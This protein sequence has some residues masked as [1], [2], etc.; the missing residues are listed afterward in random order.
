MARRRKKQ[1]LDDIMVELAM[2][3]IAGWGSGCQRTA[4]Y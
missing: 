3:L 4:R 2:K 1:T